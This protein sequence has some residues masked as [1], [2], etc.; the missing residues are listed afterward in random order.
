MCVLIDDAEFIGNSGDCQ[1]VYLRF[2]VAGGQ[3]DSR[4]KL[5]E[6]WTYNAFE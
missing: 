3:I 4:H 5:T 2:F 6:D 1:E